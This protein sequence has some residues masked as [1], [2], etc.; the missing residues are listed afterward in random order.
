MTRTGTK[1]G[2]RGGWVLRRVLEDDVIMSQRRSSE[3]LESELRRLHGLCACCH[4]SFRAERLERCVC[5][6]CQAHCVCAHCGQRFRIHADSFGRVCA[7]CWPELTRDEHLAAR[8]EELS[9]G[10]LAKELFRLAF[11]EAA[12]CVRSPAGA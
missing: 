8:L 7:S 9:R 2:V 12:A 6:N 11:G 3:P 10:A 1:N 4:R 5:A